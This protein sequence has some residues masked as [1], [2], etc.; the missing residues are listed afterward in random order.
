MKEGGQ[1][2]RTLT[3]PRTT[4]IL[5]FVILAQ[6]AALADGVT[7]FVISPATGFSI[8]TSG[9][10][11]LA[12]NATMSGNVEGITINA[13]NVTI[14]LGGHTITGGPGN[15]VSGITGAAAT[16]VT[17]FNGNVRQ[18]GVWGIQLGTRAMVRD[19]RVTENNILG[20]AGGITT[21]DNSSVE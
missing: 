10:Y 2:V 20:G 18:F 5:C 9:S 15:G 14:D 6:L 19:C 12:G 13:E 3:L 16:S 4:A 21:G 17:V 1:N 7:D 8:S 11:H